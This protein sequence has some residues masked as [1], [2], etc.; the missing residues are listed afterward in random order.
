M[1][2]S[3]RVQRPLELGAD[4]NGEASAGLG[5]ASERD[6]RRSGARGDH[7]AQGDHGAPVGGDEERRQCSW[8]LTKRG[9]AGNGA[10][11]NGS[12]GQCS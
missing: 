4:P 9:K 6:E 2:M 3:A 5:F 12:D 8:Q 11:G 10:A 1:G 7:G